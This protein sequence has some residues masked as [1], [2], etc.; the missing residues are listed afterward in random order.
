MRIASFDHR[1]GTRSRAHLGVM[2]AA[3]VIFLCGRATG[4]DRREPGL[5]A[6]SWAALPW[7]GASQAVTDLAKG[8]FLVA[9]RDLRDPNFAE[10]VVLLIEYTADGAMGVVI[11]RPTAV[12]LS[13]V[14]PE[15]EEL[16]QRADRVHIGGPVGRT[17]LLLLVQSPHRHEGAHQVF[18]DVY[19]SGSRALLHRLA[20][21]TATGEKFRAY[22]GYAGW[23]PGQLDHEVS[24][25]DWHILPATAQT[26]FDAAPEAIW[27]E[28]IRQGAVEWANATR[29][30]GNAYV[31]PQDPLH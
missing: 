20:G 5:P 14:F 26:I 6:R 30:E 1:P 31:H 21:E 10:T 11:N 22:A 23:A 2:T 3:F 17:Q 15:I 27:P 13:E 7:H 16:R 8:K 29:D 18:G 9:G 19:V 25:G 28:L 24:R 12:P 4:S